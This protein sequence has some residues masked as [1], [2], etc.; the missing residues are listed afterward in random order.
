MAKP[1]YWPGVEGYGQYLTTGPTRLQGSPDYLWYTTATPGSYAAEAAF[2]ADVTS[3]FGPIDDGPYAGE[4]EDGITP[5]RPTRRTLVSEWPRNAIA[6]GVRWKLD[7]P[8]FDPDDVPEMAPLPPKRRRSWELAGL[9]AEGLV[10]PSPCTP[11][12]AELR[13]LARRREGKAAKPK[14]RKADS[15][16]LPPPKPKNPNKSLRARQAALLRRAQDGA[17]V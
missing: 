2:I 4:W 10:A 7:P 15:Q 17:G 5:M 14:P 8:P 3:R 16:P 6:T 11:S 9:P 12:L 1:R 13:A